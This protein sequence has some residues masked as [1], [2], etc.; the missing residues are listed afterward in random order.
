[1]LIS[2]DSIILPDDLTWIDEISWT[3]VMQAVE[4]SATGALLIQESSK[5]SG[6]PIT[7]TGTQNMGWITRETVDALVV[8]RDTVG[9][10]MTLTIGGSTKNV[11][12]RQGESPVDVAPVLEGNF[13]DS[14][15]WYQVNSIK[16]MEVS[17]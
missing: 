4:Y 3:S 16:L 6:R 8:K 10:E 13:F 14:E 17:A 7:L 11:M 12:F 15:D 9:L 5:L 2:L 1:M